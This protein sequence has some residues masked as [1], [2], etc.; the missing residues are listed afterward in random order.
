MVMGKEMLVMM[1]WME[2]VGN[3]SLTSSFSDALKTCPECPVCY[4]ISCHQLLILS[5][6]MK[7][8]FGILTV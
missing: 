8:V 2:T 6:F 1:T 4:R 7:P 3:S 5:L